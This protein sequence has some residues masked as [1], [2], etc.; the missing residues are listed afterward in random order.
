MGTG[1]AECTTVGEI[2]NGVNR[3]APSGTARIAERIR[4]TNTDA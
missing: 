4:E 1:T 3:N 2:A